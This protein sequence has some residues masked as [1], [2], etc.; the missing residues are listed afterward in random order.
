MPPSPRDPDSRTAAAQRLMPA[1]LATFMSAFVAG[2]VTAINTGIDAGYPSRWLVAWMIACPAAIV[3]AYVFR[4]WAWR[5]ACG[6]ASL[7]HGAK[8][9]PRAPE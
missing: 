6:V 2:V 1:C 8:V 5:M 3:A 4:P 7:A 9:N